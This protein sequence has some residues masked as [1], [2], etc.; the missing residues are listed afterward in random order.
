LILLRQKHYGG[1]V[2][3]WTKPQAIYE[4]PVFMTD[5][6]ALLKEPRRPWID[7]DSLKQKFLSLSAEV[8]PDRVHNSGEGEK[9]RAQGRYTDLNAAYNC[10]R[11]PKSR[12]QHLLELELGVKPGSVESIP[13]DLMHL[14][15]EVSQACRDADAFLAEAA[16]V[17]SPLLKVHMFERGQEWTDKLSALQK[18]LNSRHEELMGELK[19]IDAE[20]DSD[21]KP[22][23]TKRA[24]T[25]HRLEDLYRLFSYFARWS[26][27]IQE[28]IV[29]LSF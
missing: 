28:R 13:P 4:A 27:Q 20:W 2:S 8:H 16:T 9:R 10:L 19:T 3:S 17:N 5:Y 24:V 29:Q 21:Q 23:P 6:F 11:E 18:R 22:D 15:L 25:L 7:I 14:F 1:Q 26:G 12:L